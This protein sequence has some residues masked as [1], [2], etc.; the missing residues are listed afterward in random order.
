MLIAGIDPGKAGAVAGL[1]V[2][3]G[4]VHFLDMPARGRGNDVDTDVVETTLLGWEAETG[5]AIDCVILEEQ[6]AFPGQGSVSGWTFAVNYGA[7]RDRIRSMQ[8]HRAPGLPPLQL[9]EVGGRKWQKALG[10]VMPL[11]PKRPKAQ[12]R[13]SMDGLAL[14]EDEEEK[15]KDEDAAAL[16]EHRRLLAERK[17]GVK[18][19]VKSKVRDWF[20]DAAVGN[21][22]GRADALA[23]CRYGRLLIGERGV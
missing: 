22:D 18:A 5:H 10:I 8:R 23:L 3:T 7:L 6:H 2:E 9:V 11:A 1:C 15:A 19:E 17:R 4:Q 14:T 13:V 20:P 21:A 12:A 16:K